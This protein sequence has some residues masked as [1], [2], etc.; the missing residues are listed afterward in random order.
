MNASTSET[1]TLEP[2]EQ[3]VCDQFNLFLKEGDDDQPDKTVH[4]IQSQIEKWQAARIR[5]RQ[6]VVFVKR[7]AV[8]EAALKD[9][10]VIYSVIEQSVTPQ[11]LRIQ[12]SSSRSLNLDL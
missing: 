5:D 2:S 3:E 1:A 7:L 12:S 8:W 9:L 11:T 10:M 6:S 4:F